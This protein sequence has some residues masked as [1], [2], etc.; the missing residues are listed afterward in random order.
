MT[1]IA[2]YRHKDTIYLAADRRISPSES[3]YK[4]GTTSKIILHQY[5]EEDEGPVQTVNI[6]VSGPLVGSQA[7]ELFLEAEE[8]D[9]S[10]A[11]GIYRT[12]LSFRADLHTNQLCMTDRNGVRDFAVLPMVMLIVNEKGRMF[13]VLNFGEVIEHKEFCAIGTG[14][15][16]ALG[17]M[18]A[19][20]V[21]NSKDLI[22]GQD[23]VLAALNA[24][25]YHDPATGPEFD[26]CE[27]HADY[28]DED[29]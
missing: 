17:A 13:T 5:A 9:F 4:D 3:Y 25:H 19:V 6:G 29:F 24:A 21:A 28:E 22:S 23:V 26:L 27:I 1:T 16:Y 15:Q 7:L 2:A 14:M 18:H 10:S 8:T 11:K 20:S 12:M